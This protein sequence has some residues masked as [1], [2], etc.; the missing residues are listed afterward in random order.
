MRQISR[1]LF[2]AILTLVVFGSVTYTACKKDKCKDV[3]CHNGGTCSNGICSCPAN[4]SGPTCETVGPCATVSC[5]NG[6]A[7]N[8]G[9]C[10][11]PTG[12][13]GTY[14]ETEIR[15]KFERIWTASDTNTINN[16][17]VDTTSYL[18][19]I[20]DGPSITQVGISTMFK[21]FFA[22]DVIGT[23]SGDSI[24]V[25]SQQPDASLDHHIVGNAVMIND[26]LYW[27]YTITTSGVPVNYKGTWR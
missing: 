3:S 12:Y 20:L 7:C 8:N 22:H 26:T 5:Q 13:E 10:A 23:I 25:A 21:G 11:C 15:T 24:I 9:T 2:A 14:C 17:A 19:V 16:N 27:H 18:P 1:V 6:G 4:Y